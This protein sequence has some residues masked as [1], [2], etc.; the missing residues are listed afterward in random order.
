MWP[1]PWGPKV[2]PGQR[3]HADLVE[4]LVL[5]LALVVARGGDVGEDVE[6]AGGTAAAD[7]RDAV[8]AV[9][10]NVAATAELG[11]H[12]V[13]GRVGLR[14]LEGLDGG[15]LGERGGT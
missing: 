6:S 14:R 13:H 7:P 10:Q 3:G 9:D 4:Q 11:H 12:R 1:A 2:L 8:E 15:E 5:Q